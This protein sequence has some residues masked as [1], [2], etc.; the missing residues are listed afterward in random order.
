MASFD[1]VKAYQWN[2]R[3]QIPKRPAW[4]TEWPGGKRIAVTFTIMHE[5]E[6]KPGWATG[7]LGG[8]VLP[9]RRHGE[10]LAGARG[11]LERGKLEV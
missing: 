8:M 3:P 1:F 6:S 9:L 2:Y 5:W 11:S 7:S 4:F 10:L